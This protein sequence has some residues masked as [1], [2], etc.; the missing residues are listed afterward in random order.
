MPGLVDWFGHE[1]NKK[2]IG[3]QYSKR[4]NHIYNYVDNRNDKKYSD[5]IFSSIE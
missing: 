3:M 5:K 1:N 4:Y 2:V